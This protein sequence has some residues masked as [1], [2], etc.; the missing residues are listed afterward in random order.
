[1]EFTQKN[2][3]AR[4]CKAFNCQQI[5]HVWGDRV[6]RLSGPGMTWTWWLNP[7]SAV[8]SEN[9][10]FLVVPFCVG[11]VTTGSKKHGGSSPALLPS[12]LQQACQRAGSSVMSKP[13]P[14]P[15]GPWSHRYRGSGRRGFPFFVVILLDRL[16][17]PW[18]LHLFKYDGEEVFWKWHL[19]QRHYSPKSSRDIIMSKHL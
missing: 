1:M 18:A 17:L 4:N 10:L 9:P 19:P 16:T 5:P 2:K 13:Q 12:L 7:V 8:T 6:W 3:W 11:C 15:S 14:R